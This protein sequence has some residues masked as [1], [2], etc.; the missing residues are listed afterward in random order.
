MSKT[1]ERY[2]RAIR[3]VIDGLGRKVVIYKQPTKAECPNCYFDKMTNRS[4]GEC[5]W[6]SS[7]AEAKNDPSRYKYFK[8]GRCPIC[9]GKG[10]LETHRK[11]RATCIVN[12]NPSE[13]RGGN[14]IMHT[15]AGTE[16]STVVRLKT[17]PKHFDAFK[18]CKKL[19][20][21]GVE[22][23]VSRPPTMRGLGTQA[24]LVVFAFT[25]EKP[26]IDSGEIIKDY[27]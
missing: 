10:Y 6:T 15:P 1:K 3:D 22:C 20:V 17:H 8:F 2:R 12:W 7:Q 26:K 14:L 13:R 23:K 18:N 19:L 27:S 16:G 25:T 9:L 24:V 4:T 11:A 21:D 5:K